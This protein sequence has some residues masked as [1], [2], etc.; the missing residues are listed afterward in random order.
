MQKIVVPS[1]LFELD[2][3]YDLSEF[4]HLFAMLEGLQNGELEM[5]LTDAHTAALINDFISHHDLEIKG[6]IK[7]PVV[8]GNY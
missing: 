7:A 8:H 5:A 2:K 4:P 6:M 1:N 3:D